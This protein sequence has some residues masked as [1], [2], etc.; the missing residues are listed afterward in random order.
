MNWSRRERRFAI[1]W[2]SNGRICRYRVAI[3]RLGS[4]VL[5]LCSLTA[6]ALAGTSLIK[7]EPLLLAPGD[8]ARC[9]VLRV[10][11]DCS[12]LGETP[13]SGCEN[14]DHTIGSVL[15][16]DVELVWGPRVTPEEEKEYTVERCVAMSPWQTCFATYAY[17]T[18]PGG[19]N[20][21]RVVYCRIRV[22][23]LTA[24][25]F[26]NPEGFGQREIRANLMTLRN[27]IPTGIV[28]VLDE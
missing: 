12:G 13:L 28:D 16:A 11:Q 27:G 6:V 5:V 21:L 3:V 7:T 22:G 1:C 19:G 24:E 25:G 8:T 26:I 15:T 9:T 17:P 18:P 10:P 14:S 4:Q 20:A 23:R 2:T